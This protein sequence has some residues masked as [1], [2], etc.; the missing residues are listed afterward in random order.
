[1]ERK[2][3]LFWIRE[4]YPVILVIFDAG[5]DRAYW[6]HVQQQVHGGKIF[7]LERQ[8]ASLTV[9]VPRI[10][11]MNEEAVEQFRQLKRR[12]SSQWQKGS[13]RHG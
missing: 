2:D 7:G 1:V 10:Q 12:A 4:K 8:G 5:N 3:L 6:L 11:V 9:H 13:N